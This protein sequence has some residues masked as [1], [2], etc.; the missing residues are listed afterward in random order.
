M[1]FI[2]PCPIMGYNFVCIGLYG[3]NDINSLAEESLKM[4]QFDHPN[5]LPLI[6]ICIT[7]SS[8]PYIVMPYMA[9]GSLLTYLRNERSNLVL[10]IDSDD[11]TI[12]ET[13]KLLLSMCLQVAKGMEYLALKR[14]IHRDLAARNCM[15]VRCNYTIKYN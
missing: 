1:V 2:F 13:K 5:V 7:L 8:A 6:G 9:K 14:F 10:P 11:D 3:D 12:L 4:Q 15:Y